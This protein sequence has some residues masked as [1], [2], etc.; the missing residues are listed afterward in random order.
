[1]RH[2]WAR[3]ARIDLFLTQD[4]GATGTW[5]PSNPGM[6]DGWIVRIRPGYEHLQYG[7]IS[8]ALIDLVVNGHEVKNHPER[9]AAEVYYLWRTLIDCQDAT[10]YKMDIE[11]Q[12][13]MLFMAEYFA[14]EGL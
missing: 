6:I 9:D 5:V 4:C 12:M 14:D 10:T 8:K 7:S 13:F 3:G 2:A 11:E 1:M